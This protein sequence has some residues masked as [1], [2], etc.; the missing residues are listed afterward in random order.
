MKYLT[1]SSMCNGWVATNKNT[2]ESGLAK[3]IREADIILAD[4]DGT[5][6]SPGEKLIFETL[7]DD[8]YLF[9]RKTWKWTIESI[10]SF[11]SDGMNSESK[12]WRAFVEQFLQ[13]PK[14]LA[15]V[16]KKFEKCANDTLYRGVPEFYDVLNPN[17]LKI[18]VTR[19]ITE[20]VRAYANVLGFDYYF[21][22]QFD[23]VKSAEELI[24]QFPDRK[25]FLVKG[26]SAPEQMMAEH[27]RE[28]KHRGKIEEVTYI[29]VAKNLR[30]YNPTADVNTSR[31]Q[32]SIAGWLKRNIYQQ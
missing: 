30:R 27:L 21:T 32:K 23:K 7:A 2:V 3:K 26:D 15:Q 31:N 8:R 12:V 25:R 13:N 11:A 10:Q 5:D 16:K 6:A 28:L 18:Y 4:L 17:S 29:N 20:V 1:Q 24:E 9:D 19:N 14:R 22:G